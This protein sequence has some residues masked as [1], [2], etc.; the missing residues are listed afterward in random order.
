[1]TKRC[2]CRL[3]YEQSGKVREFR[4]AM[5]LTEVIQAQEAQK[6]KKEKK[7]VTVHCLATQRVRG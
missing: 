7:K 6:K 4:S 5:L 1:M 2:A 3:L